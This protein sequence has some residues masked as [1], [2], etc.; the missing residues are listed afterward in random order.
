[1][2]KFASVRIV[3]FGD[4]DVTGVFVVVPNIAAVIDV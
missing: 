2:N 3:I 1:M 4:I